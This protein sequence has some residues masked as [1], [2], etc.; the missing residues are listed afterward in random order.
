MAVKKRNLKSTSGFP[1]KPVSRGRRWTKAEWVCIGG[2]ISMSS[3][4]LGGIAKTI[5]GKVR[6]EAHAVRWQKGTDYFDRLKDAANAHDVVDGLMAR[7]K[8][9]VEPENVYFALEEP[10]SYGHF[11]QGQSNSIKQQC[12]ISGAF[13]GGL[14]KWGY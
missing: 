2:D 7:L 4:S 6:V 3:I 14:V 12:Q 5:D 11:K 13:M 9:M 8:V 1:S 10:V